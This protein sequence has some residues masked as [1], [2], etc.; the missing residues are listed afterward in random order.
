MA[1][2]KSQVKRI[3]DSQGKVRYY[4]E[5]K[6]ISNQ[7]GSKAWVR[8]EPE[9]GPRTRLTQQES[10]F[11][12][13]SL[14][15]KKTASQR[16]RF[17]GK[18]VDNV[19]GKLVQFLNLADKGEIRKQ[20]NVKDFGDLQKILQ[21]SVGGKTPRP[22]VSDQSK[23]AAWTTPNQARA[24]TTFENVADIIETLNT[25]PIYKLMKFV[26]ITKDGERLEGAKAKEYVRDYELDMVTKIQKKNGKVA[27]VKFNHFVIPNI[28]EKSV[29]WDEEEQ[30][31]PEPQYSA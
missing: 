21:K 11:L 13:R 9:I 26:V 31:D 29:V 15:S 19:T 25:S 7:K 24:R 27:F 12:K 1:K 20:V 8:S 18:F 4:A 14:A 2:K 30:E 3:I 28:A 6:R 22:I 16:L 5:G 10:D 23:F 17:D